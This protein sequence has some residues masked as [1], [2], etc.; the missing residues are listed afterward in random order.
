VSRTSASGETLKRSNVFLNRVGVL[1]TVCPGCGSVVVK[2]GA[3]KIGT[4]KLD[5]ATRADQVVRLLP[6]FGDTTGVVTL[7]STTTG[8]EISIDG[9]IAMQG[10]TTGPG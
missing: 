10:T 9:L 3:T 2:V 8:K 5:A 7:K 4:I 6:A 1:A